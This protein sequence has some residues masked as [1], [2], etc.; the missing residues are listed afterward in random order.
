MQVY[1]D[2]DALK[3]NE[4]VEFVGVLSRAPE[5]AAPA[6]DGAFG[7]RLAPARHQWLATL[8]L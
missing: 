6:D 1:D 2:A 5:L 8:T 3:L 4:V 7:G